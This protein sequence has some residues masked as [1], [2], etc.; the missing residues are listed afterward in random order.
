MGRVRQ[1]SAR[2]RGRFDD[3]AS[4]V[5]SVLI[6]PGHGGDNIGCEHGGLVE[7]DWTLAMALDLEHW[8]RA[9]GFGVI[10]TRTEDESVSLERRGAL[11]DI[12]HIDL[13]LSLHVNAYKDP[14]QDGLM[15]FTLPD[16]PV[17]REVGS[18]IMRASPRELL[19]HKQ[20]PLPSRA[21]DWTRD[22]YSVLRH[23]AARPAVLIE[24]GFATSPRDLEILTS[25]SSRP[26]LCAAVLAGASRFHELS[27]SVD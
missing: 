6:D 22:A 1:K 23:H 15:C 8:L 9:W 25:P 7:K 26:A 5:K 4:L 21:G 24:F 17:A 20:R 2:N 10:L 18:A 19:R 12:N 3:G 27:G 11:G 14:E 16:D 13:A